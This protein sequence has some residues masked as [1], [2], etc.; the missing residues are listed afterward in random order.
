MVG[1]APWSLLVCE[2]TFV[3]SE[4]EGKRVV[5]AE[6]S[7]RAVVRSVASPIVFEVALEG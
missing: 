5:S 6:N 1:F 2:A 7:R 4:L 3:L